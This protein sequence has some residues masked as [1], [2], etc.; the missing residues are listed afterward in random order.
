MFGVEVDL[1]YRYS[2]MGTSPFSGL[3]KMAV[4]WLSTKSKY[5]NKYNPPRISISLHDALQL[6]FATVVIRNHMGKLNVHFVVILYSRS[7]TAQPKSLAVN[8]R[9]LM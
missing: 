4:I 5:K 7:L 6:N 2:D 3:G 8:A 9:G 1:E